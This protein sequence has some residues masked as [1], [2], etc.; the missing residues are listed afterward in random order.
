MVGRSA[1]PGGARGAEA[2]KALSRIWAKRIQSLDGYQLEL[3]WNMI[4]AATRAPRR[5]GK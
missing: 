4:D 2:V 3:I 1:S 5:K